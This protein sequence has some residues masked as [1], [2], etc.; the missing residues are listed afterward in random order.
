[1]TRTVARIL[2]TLLIL[3][4]GAGFALLVLRAYNSLN[5]PA[6]QPWHTFVPTEL[7]ADEIDHADWARYLAQEDLVMR[8]V[9]TEVTDKLP[10]ETRVPANRY[11]EQSPVFPPHFAQDWN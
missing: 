9:R 10:P 11:Y 3:I 5:G 1:M 8:Q 4:I 6:L 2:R 7:H